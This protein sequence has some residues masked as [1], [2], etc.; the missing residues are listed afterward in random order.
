MSTNLPCHKGVGRRHGRNGPPR[1]AN[2][3]MGIPNHHHHVRGTHRLDS[4]SLDSNRSRRIHGE[5]PYVTH[6]DGITRYYADRCYLDAPTGLL[7]YQLEKKNKSGPSRHGGGAHDVEYCNKCG[8]IRNIQQYRGVSNNTPPPPPPPRPLFDRAKFINSLDLSAAI[9]GTYTIGDF[10]YLSQELPMLFP[11]SLLDGKRDNER[12][13]VDHVPTLVLHGQKG[14]SLEKWSA[15]SKEPSD[16]KDTGTAKSDEQ[17]MSIRGGGGESSQ[18]SILT[19]QITIRSKQDDHSKNNNKKKSPAKMKKRPCLTFGG[20]KLKLPKTPKRL[21]TSKNKSKAVEQ[22]QQQQNDAESEENIDNDSESLI[23]QHKAENNC[24]DTA[25]ANIGEASQQDQQHSAENFSTQEVEVLDVKVVA[26]RKVG[27]EV[28]DL[29]DSDSEDEQ[30]VPEVPKQTIKSEMKTELPSK[31]PSKPSVVK[32]PKSS[33]IKS[34]QKTLPKNEP[35]SNAAPQPCSQQQ[36]EATAASI[37]TRALGKHTK[38]KTMRPIFYNSGPDSSQD[39]S[40]SASDSKRL[41]EGIDKLNEKRAAQEKQKRIGWGAVKPASTFGGEVFFT[42]VLPRWRPPP[43]PKAKKRQ[44]EA[45][46]KKRKACLNTS[47]E[48]SDDDGGIGQDKA[49][50]AP[51]EELKSVRGVHHPKFFLLFE[52]SGSLVVIISTSNLTPQNSLDGSWVQRFEPKSSLPRPTYINNGSGNSDGV[53]VGMPSDFGVVLT[54]FLKK[55]SEAAASGTMMPDVFLRRYVSGLSSGLNSL[56]DH[57]HF[58]DAQVHL[59]STVPGD[60]VSG[61]PFRA[62][63]LGKVSYGPQRVQ[64]ILSRILNDCHIQSARA[65]MGRS[66]MDASKPWLPQYLVSAKDRLVVQPTSLGGN[67]TRDDLEDI[68]KSYLQPHWELSGNAYGPLE[69][70]DIVW[71]TMDFFDEMRAR[72]RVLWKSNPEEAAKI[73]TRWPSMK[74][75]GEGHVFLS[76]VSFARLDR[77]CI[78]RMALFNP[79]PNAMPYNTSSLHFKSVCRLLRV[80]GNKFLPHSKA[81]KSET[82]Q[83]SVNATKEYLSW[84]MLTSACL[85]RGAQGQPTPY[86]DPATDSMSYSNFELGVLFC[87]RLVGDNKFDRIYVSDPNHQ[88]GCS[89]G[90]GK[91]FYFKDHNFGQDS[92]NSA[93]LKCVKKVHLPIPY[94]LRPT[95]YQDDP[96]SDFMSH[97]PYLNEIPDGTGCAGN[98]KLT[99]LGQQIADDINRKEGGTM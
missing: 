73:T 44:E 74:K 46:K 11:P 68:A 32:L 87:S 48:Y 29:L 26:K 70:M 23:Q 40:M 1:S 47:A 27:V 88:C 80:N 52:R 97:T 17:L 86:R 75:K 58:D 76:S 91:R 77:S 22:K 5:V 85:S 50:T 8:E 62:T 37:L 39:S 9:V 14:F 24:R 84:F 42:Q 33:V 10:E 65:K 41:Q 78:S 82:K 2:S 3:I 19:E 99:P 92:D 59:V 21:R 93:F 13:H 69:L 56:S 57:Y 38:T 95:P 94:E 49:T 66:Q 16:A 28:I 6:D 51:E 36:K 83:A 98:M 55:Q 79:L 31:A 4:A 30:D 45:A 71:P 96:D 72:R 15:A 25:S 89:C 12:R 43:S 7:E 64:F 60:H 63:S 81:I 35:T 54:D 67:W 53:D 61:L 18:E 20:H 34:E 90:K